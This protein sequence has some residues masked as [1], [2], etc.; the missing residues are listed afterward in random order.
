MIDVS[1]FISICI[2]K[3]EVD[4]NSI[5]FAKNFCDPFKENSCN[6]FVYTRNEATGTDVMDQLTFY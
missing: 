4:W 6:T 3:A 1:W 5:L 2:S